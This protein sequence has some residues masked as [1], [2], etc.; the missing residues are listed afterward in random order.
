MES[1]PVTAAEYVKNP[2]KA[3][4]DIR[5]AL[6]RFEQAYDSTLEKTGGPEPWSA[7]EWRFSQN[8]S[9]NLTDMRVCERLKFVFR[10]VDLASMRE[11]ELFGILNP[12]DEGSVVVSWISMFM[13][14]ANGK[15]MFCID[16]YP[17][18]RLERQLELFEFEILTSDRFVNPGD[19]R[20]KDTANSELLK[21]SAPEAKAF[22]AGKKWCTA[23]YA[24]ERF[25]INA[26]QLSKASTKS[27]GLYAIKVARRM[28]EQGLYVFHRGDLQLLSDAIEKARGE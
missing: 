27:I 11:P 13:Q 18:R 23:E 12:W 7:D 6:A 25:G 19:N 10:C 14:E 21:E 3:L 1:V 26:S 28:N 5:D 2:R 16:G 24:A 20:G 8:D 9:V 15:E 4:E 17:L 22:M